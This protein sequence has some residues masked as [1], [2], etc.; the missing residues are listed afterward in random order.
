VK[1]LFELKNARRVLVEEN[2]F[3]NNW[4]DAQAGFALTWKSVNQDGGAPWSQTSDVIFRRNVVRNSAAGL[5]ISARPEQAPAVPATRF[6]VEQNLFEGIGSFNGTQNGRMIFLG[7]GLTDVT[8]SQNTFVH[9]SFSSSG[10]FIIMDTPD[11]GR[12]LV[13]KNN[14][15]TWGGPYGAVMGTARQGTDALNAFARP[16]TFHG[17]VI[18][19]LPRSLTGFYPPGNTFLDQLPDA[20]FVNPGRGDY[21]R[22][23]TNRLR[24]AGA[25]VDALM[26]A[27]AGVR[28]P[29][30]RGTS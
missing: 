3:E 21:R 30:S 17:N 2:V 11:G 24:Y 13:I 28:Q 1:N 20:G 19:G 16:F 22:S 4:A 15:A 7:G 18:I 23:T 10:Q 5:S 6:L 25:D 14:L 8:I 27:T 9:N 29:A 12:H 26:R